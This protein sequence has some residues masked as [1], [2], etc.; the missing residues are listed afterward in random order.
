MTYAI[1]L[2]LTVAVIGYG[3]YVLFPQAMK[4]SG[5][6]TKRWAYLFGG[7]LFAELMLFVVA[8]VVG[9]WMPPYRSTYGGDIDLLFYVIL[10]VT[11]VTFIGVSIV[12]VYVLFKYPADPARRAIYTHGDHKLEMI[13][14]AAPGVLL[15]LLAIGQIPAWVKV[16]IQNLDDTSAAQSIQMEVTAR[17]WEWRV[18]YPSASH[19]EEWRK[20]SG[21]AMHDVRTRL[22]PRPDDVRLVNEVH[23]VKG[24]RMLIYLKTQD[25][26]HSF[27]LPHMRLKQDALP[28]KTIL[29]WF[30]PIDANC[31]KVGDQ[32][33]DGRRHDPQKGWV[34]DPGFV[35][36]LAC[37]E[38]CGSR[39]SMMR[40]KLFVHE[41]R[42]DFEAWLKAAETKQQARMPETPIK[43]AVPGGAN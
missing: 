25:V 3:V 40:G 6:G 18:R 30:E 7:T 10:A 11:G 15:F 21:A 1:I 31:E 28:G 17:Q 8:P 20:Q 35:W 43:P 12:F 16:K 22:A 29:V 13:W 24:Q 2:L 19:L 26:I 34:E 37:A 27:F 9:W 5:K 42:D 38:Y 4:P 41:T 32:W 33:V 39:H 23:A 36:E 14:T